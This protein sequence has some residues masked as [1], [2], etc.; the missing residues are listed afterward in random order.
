ME[1]HVFG[2]AFVDE[3]LNTNTEEPMFWE[4]RMENLYADHKPNIYVAVADVSVYEHTLSHLAYFRDTFSN[5][6]REYRYFIH[7]NN[8]VILISTDYRM[9]SIDR[10]LKELGKFFTRYR[11]FAG[12]SEAFRDLSEF[13]RR[14]TQALNALN[15]GMEQNNGRYIF[16]YDTFRFDCFL[17]TVKTAAQLRELCNPNVTLI[18]EHDKVRHVSYGDTLR[19][20]LTCG[21]NIALA[22]AQTQ[23]TPK[24]LRARLKAVETAYEIDWDDG[25]LLFSLLASFKIL[26]CT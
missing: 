17:N 26:D 13:Q 3:L 1:E 12:V 2:E 14:Y 25:N 4:A 16:K 11:V 24:E 20:F 21:K 15:H 23:L 6:Q 5:L 8:I 9:L 7:L 19:A 18:L 22:C 10:D